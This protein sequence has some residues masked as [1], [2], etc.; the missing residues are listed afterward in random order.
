MMLNE[1]KKAWLHE[2]PG[3][4]IID[5]PPGIGMHDEGGTPGIVSLLREMLGDD[6]IY[7][8][9]RLDKATSGLLILGK[10]VDNTR[11]ISELFSTKQI[12]KYY[13]AV[14]AAKPK[15]KQG[16]VLGDMLQARGGSWKLSQTRNN[17]AVTQFFS[18]GLE[19]LR[20]F[21]L[22]PATGKTH[23]IRVALKSLSAPVLGDERYGGNSLAMSEKLYKYLSHEGT[24]GSSQSVVDHRELARASPSPE[25]SGAGLQSQTKSKI[26]RMYLHAYCV[27][28]TLYNT[29]YEFKRSPGLGC[30]FTSHIFQTQLATL[31]DVSAMPWPDIHRFLN[32]NPTTEE[33]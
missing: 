20:L 25:T 15:K 32:L 28:F 6:D 24:L 11:A 26:D 16:I 22:K 19:G 31:A 4:F 8:C 5:K 9:H 10:G 29:E 12:Q 13:L 7:P 21:L 30:V 33:R 27:Q 1:I 3:F 18:F 2:E 17:P 14:S 23:Q